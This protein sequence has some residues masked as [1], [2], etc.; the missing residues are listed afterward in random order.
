MSPGIPCQGCGGRGEGTR[1]IPRQ[2]APCKDVGGEQQAPIRTY[3]GLTTLGIIGSERG[4]LGL[5]PFTPLVGRPGFSGL[6]K[7]VG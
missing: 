2:T 5:I 7:R 1:A 3:P 4:P 6:A